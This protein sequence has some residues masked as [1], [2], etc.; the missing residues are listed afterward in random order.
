MWAGEDL[1]EDPMPNV[2]QG[3]A[4]VPR[5]TAVFPRCGWRQ[6]EALSLCSVAVDGEGTCGAWQKC[7]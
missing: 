4:R 2:F 6:H 5:W 7:L 1:D 3:K